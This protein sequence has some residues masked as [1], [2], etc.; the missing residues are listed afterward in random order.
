MSR[1]SQKLNQALKEVKKQI[2]Q[3]KNNKSPKKL[4]KPA[5]CSLEP[6]EIESEPF[7]GTGLIF[8]SGTTVHG[9][10]TKFLQELSQNDF[11]IIRT[12]KTEEKRKVILVLSDKSACIA[13]SF[14]EEINT[15]F[16]I[17]KASIKVDP[18]AEENEKIEKKR[19][20]EEGEKTYEIR[21][22]RGP[23]TYK[24][25]QVKSLGKLTGE[26][27]LNVRAQRVRDKFCW[28]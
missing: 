18:K 24:T 8:V 26:D 19:K 5:E 11:L 2:N 12:E 22:K 21:V 1:P 6:Y 4:K 17:Q 20:I 13:S 16:F 14:P 28:M 23:W 10:N 25:D 9:L 7:K 3:L 27:L 15:E